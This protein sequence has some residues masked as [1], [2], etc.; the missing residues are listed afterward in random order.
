[1]CCG[2]GAKRVVDT[3]ARTPEDVQE[4]LSSLAESRDENEHT[5]YCVPRVAFGSSVLPAIQQFL[6]QLLPN[7]AAG[8][9]AP[10]EGEAE[11]DVEDLRLPSH[12]D[13]NPE[14]IVHARGER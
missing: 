7:S 14:P 13:A 5:A 6:V 2:P 11:G 10:R 4:L 8:D 1:M 9:V 12:P 3:A